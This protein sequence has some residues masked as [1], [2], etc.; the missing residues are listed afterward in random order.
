MRGDNI[1]KNRFTLLW[2]SSE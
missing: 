1:F 2:S